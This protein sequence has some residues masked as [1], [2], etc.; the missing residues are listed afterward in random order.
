MEGCIF[1]YRP[2]L[3]TLGAVLARST[4]VFASLTIWTVAI[5]GG[6]GCATQES[7]ESGTPESPAP[8]HIGDSDSD[9]DSDAGTDTASSVGDVDA[10]G[11]GHPAGG[12]DCDD[13]DSAVYPGAPERCNGLDDD[14]ND[15]VPARESTD[16]DTDGEAAC[17]D[18]DDLDSALL[19]GDGSCDAYQFTFGYFSVE[20]AEDIADVAAL[21]INRVHSYGFGAW[22][23]DDI[24]AEIAWAQ[25]Y[26][27]EAQM[28]DVM[29]L[30]DLNGA[31]WVY[32]DGLPDDFQAFAAGV[33]DHPALA[34]WYLVDEPESFGFSRDA[35]M[36]YGETLDALALD[37][38]VAASHC[39]C[40]G[41]ADYPDMA[42]IQIPDNYVVFDDAV[43]AADAHEP[44][45]FAAQVKAH[46]ADSAVEPIL[47]GFNYAVYS[48]SN[49]DAYPEDS[50]F[51][52][53]DELR[54]WA[55]S[56]LS[57]GI[58]GLW[59][60]SWYRANEHAGGP[61]WVADTFAP[62]L[63]ELVAFT[64]EA[65]PAGHP[66]QVS[67]APSGETHTYLSYWP[68][69]HATL[70][71]ATNGSSDARTLDIDLGLDFAA[72]ELSGWDDTSAV[73]LDGVGR[74]NVE[75]EPY[76]VFVWVTEAL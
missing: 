18:C 4:Y 70:V 67:G 20:E 61:A 72:A 19:T 50:R 35:V 63:A 42:D 55:Y 39:S 47:Q 41:W 27:D 5:V 17:L 48:S 56:D 54:F 37:L 3:A 66:V 25:A 46:Y 22:P 57:L 45:A 40:D 69:P 38:P 34:A 2:M 62:V 26:L 13:T 59:W 73:T 33:A 49:P 44:P 23:G 30:G 31:W 16:Q 21:G 11:D 75:A 6:L 15:E 12:G 74:A 28:L 36:T 9:S 68:R 7:N 24:D 53:T 76:Q 71:V 64:E 29:V 32:Y 14:C 52:T 8:E 58:D 43:P 51:P 60:W 65:L 10:D 1:P